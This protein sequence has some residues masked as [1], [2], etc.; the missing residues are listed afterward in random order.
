ML[1]V[2]F[3]YLLT[4]SQKRQQVP[5]K[6]SSKVLL[7]RTSPYGQ[8]TVIMKPQ[9]VYDQVFFFFFSR[10]MLSH[11]LSESCVYSG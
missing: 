8:G 3:V 6:G 11:L 1:K 4:L 7:K 9:A 10:L 2:I 5:G